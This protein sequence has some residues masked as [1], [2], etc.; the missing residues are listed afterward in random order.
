MSDQIAA[1]MAEKYASDRWEEM[2]W[3]VRFDFIARHYNNF[4]R[5]TAG[6]YQMN[7]AAVGMRALAWRCAN[8]DFEAVTRM[9][10]ERNSVGRF[11]PGLY[12]AVL[13]ELI[14]TPPAGLNDPKTL[15]QFGPEGKDDDDDLPPVL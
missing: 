13:A 14:T 15:D 12:E 10:Q 1:D 9:L 7:P 2:E 8:G 3:V 5:Q 4:R 6:W 11:Y